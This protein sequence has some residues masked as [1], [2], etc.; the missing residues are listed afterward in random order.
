MNLFSSHSTQPRKFKTEGS[1]TL[2]EP[3][4]AAPGGSSRPDHAVCSVR[5][6]TRSAPGALLSPCSGY[7]VVHLMGDEEQG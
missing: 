4:N 6:S 5:T 2:T 1:Q 3:A 7:T